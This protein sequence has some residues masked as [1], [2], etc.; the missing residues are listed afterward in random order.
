MRQ[1]SPSKRITKHPVD[2]TRIRKRPRQF[3]CV[4]RALVYQKHICRMS[5]PE[6]ALYVFLECV[7]DPQGLSYYSDQRICQY[8]QLNLDQL[9]HTRAALISKQIILY[10][11]PI[12]QVLDLPTA[13][14][15]STA[16]S[17]PKPAPSPKR[18]SE[19]TVAVSTVIHS[20]MEDLSHADA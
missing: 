4:D 17:V 3:A 7:S 14:N 1:P 15:A 2:P 6:I 8:L 5:L 20:I 19:K 10:A 16:N 9:R 13:A 11:C 18:S 12:Y